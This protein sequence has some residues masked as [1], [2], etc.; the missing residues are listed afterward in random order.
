MRKLSIAI[1]VACL[2]AGLP[3]VAREPVQ[4]TTTAS[5]PSVYRFTVGEIPVTALSDGTVPLD[6]HTL[7]RGI[8][9]AELDRRLSGAGASNPLPVS[10]NAFLIELPGRKVLLDTGAGDLFG[11]GVGGHLPAALAAAGVAPGEISDVLI[12]HTHVDHAGGLARDGRLMFPN[13]AVHIAKADV[14]FFLDPSNAARTG[15]NIQFF[16]RAK[17]M[18]DPV[19]AAGKLKTFAVSGEVV[20]GVTAELHPGHTPGLTFYTL[21]SQGMRL[22]FVGDLVHVLPVQFSRPDVTIT[23]DQDPAAARAA[24][25]QSFATFA[26]DHTLIAVPHLPFP[27]VGHVVRSGDG[28]RWSP[29]QPPARPKPRGD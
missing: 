14:D 26:R 17:A 27:G 3:A 23:F 25:E 7:L 8:G 20:P 12:T 6:L 16:E 2:A 24:R 9:A 10:I 11:P 5:R 4:T 22:V 1:A 15:Y 13:A 18:L 28:Y 29:L 19:I 21:V